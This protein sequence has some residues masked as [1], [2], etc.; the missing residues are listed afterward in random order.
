MRKRDPEVLNANVT[1]GHISA[2]YC[3]L[4]NDSYMLGCEDS[5]GSIERT[6]GGDPEAQDAAR[7]FAAHLDANGV[8]LDEHR[9]TFGR[10]LAVDREEQRY[11]GD[12]EASALMR[13]TYREG[14][15][16]PGKG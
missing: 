13:G 2:A 14:F 7:R 11:V 12:D 5:M 10:V 6:L 16:V 4:A 1:E 9:P 3:H 15:S 8:D